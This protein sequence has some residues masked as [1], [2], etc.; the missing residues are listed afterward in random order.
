MDDSPSPDR[1][2]RPHVVIVGGGFGGVPAVRALRHEAVDVTL[3]DRNAYNT[4]QPLLYQVATAALN[5]GDITYFLRA[6]RAQQENV[7]VRKA[8]VTGV[9]P[10]MQTL[11]LETGETL[12]YDYLVVATGV[13]TNYFN[14]MGAAE[15]SLALYTRTEALDMRDRLFSRLEQVATNRP[16]TGVTVVIV[17]GG[18]TGVEM[19]GSL[20]EL[21]NTTVPIIYPELDPEQTHIVLVEMADYLLA[22]FTPRLRKYT[23]RTLRNRGVDLRLST[24]VKEVREDGVVVNDGEFIPAD[25]VIWASG[26][27]APDV[28]ADWGLPQGKGGRIEVRPDLRVKGFDNVFAVGDIAQTSLPQVA[29]PAMQGGK[30]VGRQIAALV[31]GS[32]TEPFHYWDKGMLAVIGRSSGVA[33][34]KHLPGFAG[35]PAWL[36]W[37]AIHIVYLLDNRNRFATFVNLSVRYIFWRRHPVAI[38]GEVPT[39]PGIATDPRRTS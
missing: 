11:Q 7:Q 4:F 39:P 20:S 26:I 22:P 29:Q 36:V 19:A 3:I 28:V 38:V 10:Q 8:A 17:G 35:L 37:L 25:L 15:H 32:P 31:S 24:T 23:A 1:P 5:P 27:T 13:T 6:L 14:V 33:Q 18:A 30:H 12:R 34:I 9:D 21:R 16:G 2:A